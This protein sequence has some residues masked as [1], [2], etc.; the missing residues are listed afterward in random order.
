MPGLRKSIQKALENTKRQHRRGA[1]S[2]V[3]CI[4]FVCD[5][6]SA[7]LHLSIERLREA[8]EKFRLVLTA[9]CSD[10]RIEIAICAETSAER[11]M[12]VYH[13]YRSM[14]SA[15]PRNVCSV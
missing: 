6:M 12:D 4:R 5:L 7:C 15:E 14:S 8:I 1:T 9:L 2:Y 10:F 11:D 13:G 3:Q